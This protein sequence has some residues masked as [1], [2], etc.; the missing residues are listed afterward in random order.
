[1][2]YIDDIVLATE[3][4]EDHMEKFKEI[5]ECLRE[6]GFK[7]RVSKCDFMKSKIKHLGRVVSAEG[8]KPDPKTW[9][10]PIITK[11]SFPGTRN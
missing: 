1:M 4:I 9:G 10:L 3:T 2:D 7:M 5:F 6:A 8:I 11:I